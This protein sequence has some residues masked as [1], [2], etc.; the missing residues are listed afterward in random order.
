MGTNTVR[1]VCHAT[2]CRAQYD[3]RLTAEDA[4]AR[5]WPNRCGVC[6]SRAVT[7]TAAPAERRV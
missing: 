5:V 1:V 3:Q 4:R 7:V 2:D 6:G